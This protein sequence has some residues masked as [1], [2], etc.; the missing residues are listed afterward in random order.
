MAGSLILINSV[1]VSSS[2]ATVNL[3]GIDSTYDVYKVVADNIRPD[4]ADLLQIRVTKSGSAQTD[5]EYDYS[6]KQMY[7]G[8]S[9]VNESGTNLDRWKVPSNFEETTATGRGNGTIMYLFNFPEA[10]EFSFMT[11]EQSY[12]HSSGATGGN[13]GGGVHTVA[14][15]SDGVNF[16]FH[17]SNNFEEGNFKLYGLKK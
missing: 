11:L 9:Y 14:S 8:G 10:D 2:T 12:L 6:Y 3:T 4:V 16:Y 15:A 17:S 5:S 1:S 7:T 13:Q